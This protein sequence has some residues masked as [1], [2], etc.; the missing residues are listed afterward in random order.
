MP[1]RESAR[2]RREN[3]ELRE[4]VRQLRALLIPASP[5]PPEWKLT[6]R[7]AE[8]LRVL[9]ATDVATFE[10]LLVAVYGMASEVVPQ[11]HRQHIK[12]LRRKV[13]AHGIHIAAIHGIGYALTDRRKWKERLEW[14]GGTKP[15][16]S[17]VA[18]RSRGA[19]NAG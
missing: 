6:R 9:L 18:R 14:H 16:P 1:E 12:S 3:E 10:R 11:I 15:Q 8:Y 4:E 5:I 19:S 13:A 17:S 2:L 7:E